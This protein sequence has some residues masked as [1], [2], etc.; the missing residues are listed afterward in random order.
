MKWLLDKIGQIKFLREILLLFLLLVVHNNLLYKKDFDRNEAYIT[1]DGKGY[2]EYLPAIFIYNDLKFAYIDTLKTD[3]Y[4]IEHNKMIFSYNEKGDRVDKYFVGTAVMQSP[5]FLVSHYYTKNFNQKYKADGYSMPYQVGIKCAAL[6]YV[7][8]GLVCLRL[9][10]QT[11]N[12]NTWWILLIQVTTLF[13]TPLLNYSIYDVAFSHVYSFFLITWFLYVVRKY[14]L[15]NNPRLIVL[16]VIILGLIII[17]RPINLLILLFT[18]LLVE[19]LK[20]YCD[21]IKVIFCSHIR[22]FLIAIIC[23]CFVIGIQ[24]IISYCQTGNPFNYGYGNEGFE[25]LNPKI[26]DFLFSY[27]KGFF[28]W[29]PWWFFVFVLGII[30]WLFKKTYYKVFSF[31]IAFFVLIYVLSSW[32]AWSYGASIGQRPMVDFYGAFILVIIPIVADTKKF[33][34]I[35]ILLTFPVFLVVMQIQTY[36]YQ[37]AIILWDGMDREKYWNVFLETNE[38]Y[39]WYL[40]Y[41]KQE[42]G[43]MINS[44]LLMDEIS[45]DK[46]TEFAQLVYFQFPILDSSAM[47][48]EISVKVNRE[49]DKEY[50]C[51]GF[52]D[53]D[54]TF[55]NE[56]YHGLFFNQEQNKIICR[57][58]L[59]D[60]VKLHTLVLNLH[61]VESPIKFNTLTFSTYKSLN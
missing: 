60:K 18:P 38:K 50:F 58:P 32:H 52:A 29:T 57:F 13:A 24:L 54:G 39:S 9:L 48:G 12:V 17:V 1:S 5:F 49:S 15:T 40:T 31:L 33:F 14:F 55:F 11:Y 34:K 30:C 4:E 3:Y 45:I 36:Q 53:K 43:E 21:K 46:P 25:F 59:S 8:L 7:F 61:R 19:S 26:F 35:L 23:F 20:E 42:V 2:Y 44:S 47:F 22:Y 37:R 27:Q 10:L 28:L 56:S 51:V 6:F 16:S 41:R